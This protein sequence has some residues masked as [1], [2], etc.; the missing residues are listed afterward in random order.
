MNILIDCL[1]RSVRIGG[2]EYAINTDFRACV[3][4]EIM[5]EKGEKDLVKLFRPFYP[6]GLPHDAEGA[7]NAALWFFRCG[8]PEPEEKTHSKKGYSF[9]VD[10]GAIFA[11]F[12]RF[13]NI[14]LS[15]EGLH[16]WT[17][18]ALLSGLP[19][20]SEFKERIYYRTCDLKDLP[21]K[22]KKRINE[23]RKAIEI[24]NENGGK[25]TLE[26]RNAMMLAYVARRTSE[27]QKGV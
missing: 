4:F 26:E 18:R 5:V 10:S 17:F 8:E 22:E 12:W 7:V 13:Y 3:A 27:A 6:N 24:K 23:I 2:R 14:D 19:Q 15:E 20:E 9:A 1:P 16:W 25:M 11:D 21:N